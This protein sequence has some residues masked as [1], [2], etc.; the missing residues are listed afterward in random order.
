MLKESEKLFQDINNIIV[1]IEDSSIDLS[2]IKAACTECII[3]KL[4]AEFEK[5]L[6]KDVIYN[7]LASNRKNAFDLLNTD[8]HKMPK[9]LKTF[10]DKI[11][12]NN[13]EDIE[14]IQKIR[15]LDTIR[16]NNI[17]HTSALCQSIAWEELPSY[18]EKANVFLE[19]VKQYLESN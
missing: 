6:K 9:F 13:I 4:F 3:I 5:C 10:I 18:I 16:N 12:K 2:L 19:Q 7:Y 17:A 8:S 14:C 1:G 11:I 15:N